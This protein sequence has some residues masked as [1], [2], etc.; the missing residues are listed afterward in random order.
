[1]KSCKT[2]NNTT[3]Q[4]LPHGFRY[5]ATYNGKQYYFPLGIVKKEAEDRADA[6]RSALQFE[7]IDV[8]RR[9]FHPKHA[10]A[11][12]PTIGEVLDAHKKVEEALGLKSR[13]AK[14]YRAAL[15]RMVSLFGGTLNNSVVELNVAFVA[16]AKLAYRSNRGYKGRILRSFNSMLRMAKAV[17]SRESRSAMEAV[18]VGWDFSFMEK[19]YG[20]L[21]ARP[22]KRVNKKW[23]CM[24]P[25]DIQELVW[26][27]ENLAGGELY[28]ILA[29]ALYGGLRRAEICHIQTDWMAE[30]IYPDFHY[31]HICDT[32][33]FKP[34]GRQGCTLMHRVKWDRILERRTAFSHRLIRFNNPRVV[35]DKAVNFLRKTCGLNV[36][37]PLHE[38]RKL[39][40]AYFTN[41]YGMW[42]AQKFLRHEDPKTTSDYYSDVVLP[43]KILE[44]WEK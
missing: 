4:I 9:R 36:Q 7:S 28:A 16:S 19:G 39:A 12:V 44:L 23:V 14:D 43:D 38:L 41:R 40:G 24:Q 33:I 27:I 25:K 11:K 22:F 5:R 42:E 30:S 32:G 18:C 29:L 17:F 2:K 6:I 15:R 8:V 21:K 20:F 3:V 1:M 13:T 26:K 10:L 34:K 35:S 37:K 31:L